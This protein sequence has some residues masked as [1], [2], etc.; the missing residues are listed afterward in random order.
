MALQKTITTDF[1]TSGNYSKI[2]EFHGNRNGNTSTVSFMVQLF[3][4]N[5]ARLDNKKPLKIDMFEITIP[6]GTGNDL[7]VDLYSHLKTLDEFSGA[8]DV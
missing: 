3:A 8:T 7:L 1:G 2:S 4:D 5:Q 6:T